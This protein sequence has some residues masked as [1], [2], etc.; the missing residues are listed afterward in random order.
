MSTGPPFERLYAV[1]PDGVAQMIPSHGWRPS[2]SPPT[3]SSS[4]IMRPSDALDDD[5]VVDGDR[6]TVGM[7][8]LE[9]RQLDDVVLACE[10]APQTLLELAPTH[11]AQESD[12]AEVHADHGHPGPEEARERAQHR[13]VAAEDDREVGRT[14]LVARLDAVLLGLVG[15]EDE[16]DPVLLRDRLQTRE[17][18]SRSGRACRAS[19]R[20]RAPTRLPD[21]VGDPAVDVIGIGFAGSMLEVDEELP[22][23]LRA[24]QPGVYDSDRHATPRARCFDDR[25]EHVSLHTRDRARPPSP[26]RCGPPRTAA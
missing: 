12:A 26:P 10:D 19:R 17:A 24:G 23:P 13:S 16:L 9:R 14:R 22:V 7:L 6:A 18:R 5:D 11:R 3:A 2:S 15:G 4:S 25:L 8:E 21:G 1:E 20:P